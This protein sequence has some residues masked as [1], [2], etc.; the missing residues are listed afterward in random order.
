MTPAPV[1]RLP[2]FEHIV[3]EHGIDIWRFAASQVGRERADDVFQETM[4]AA[5][6]AY[7]S[8]RDPAAVRSW[9]LRIAA[10]KA[11]DLF[12]ATARAPVSVAEPD[13]GAQAEPELRDDEL[14]AYARALPDKQRQALGLRF[15]LD[16]PYADIGAAMA[17]SAEAARRNV[18]EALKALRIRHD[19]SVTKP[20]DAEADLTS[21]SARLSSGA[22]ARL[23]GGS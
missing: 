21:R 10:R 4:L 8:L 15:V 7:A 16:L 18:F 20:A 5:L 17:T 19:Q 2:P 11:V 3:A 12:R 14:W 23:Q 1:S 13:P 6:S 9:L 22:H